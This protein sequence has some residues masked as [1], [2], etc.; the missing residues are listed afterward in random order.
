MTG[1]INRREM[2]ARINRMTARANGALLMLDLDRFKN[3]NDYYGHAAGDEVIVDFS[4]RIKNA[5][6]NDDWA[7]RIGGEEFVVWLPNVKPASALQITERLRKDI[8]VTPLELDDVTINYTVSIGLHIVENDPPSLFDSWIKAA[9]ELL[10]R[11][12]SEGRNR[13]V[14][15]SELIA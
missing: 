13:V 5:L 15:N 12:K 14:F 2:Y 4:R 6:R 1:C 10:Y 11:A 7:A 9:D 8:E 3:I